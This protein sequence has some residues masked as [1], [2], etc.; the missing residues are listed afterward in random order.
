[1]CVCVCVCACVRV[2]VF[3]SFCGLRVTRQTF[4]KKIQ[5]LKMHTEEF[6]SPT[7]LLHCSDNLKLGGG[8]EEQALPSQQEF[9]VAGDI[10]ASDV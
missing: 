1:M 9:Q 10:P 5:Q 4:C 3:T 7:N 2:S 6:T 8:L